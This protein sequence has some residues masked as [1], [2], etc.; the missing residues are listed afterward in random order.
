MHNLPDPN[1][2]TGSKLAL[3]MSKAMGSPVRRPYQTASKGKRLD[4]A[5]IDKRCVALKKRSLKLLEAMENEDTRI[6]FDVADKRCSADLEVNKRIG[7]LIGRM[8][9]QHTVLH[10]QL[11]KL[12]DTMMLQ[13]CGER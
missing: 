3:A 5:E 4:F 2:I 1:V 10:S 8:M 11:E 7:K 12:L 9:D 13:I 6:S